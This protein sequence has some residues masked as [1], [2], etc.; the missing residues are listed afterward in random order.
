MPSYCIDLSSYNTLARYRGIGNYEAGLA[1]GLEAI[2]SQLAPDER[3]LAVFSTDEVPHETPLHPEAHAA[4]LPPPARQTAHYDRYFARRWLQ[5][6][7]TLIRHAPDVVHFVEGPQAM[8]SNRYASV[9]TCH[10]LI[11]LRMPQWYISR[12]LWNEPIRRA[13]DYLRYHLADRLIAVSYATALDMEQ[14][15]AIPRQRITV[16]HPGVNH[17]VFRPEAP[18]GERATQVRRFSL[19]VR[20]CLYVGACDHRKQ[21]DLLLRAYRQI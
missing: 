13:K 11:P 1:H 5:L 4:S 14:I 16:V 19:P 7:P 21:V 20:Y 8:L 18:P 2:R 10:D 6:Y 15:L 12:R 9:V 17:E 3:F